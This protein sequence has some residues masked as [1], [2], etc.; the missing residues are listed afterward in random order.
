MAVPPST[1]TLQCTYPAEDG[2]PDARRPTALSGPPTVADSVRPVRRQPGDPEP[3][4][5]PAVRHDRRARDRRRLVAREEEGDARDLLGPEEPPER[6]LGGDVLPRAPAELRE[7]SEERRV[8]ASG[9]DAVGTD[10]PAAVLERHRPGQI[11]D[12]GL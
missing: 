11:D 9:T 5:E 12:R 8:D 1:R 4:G 7:E 3:G 10:V 2:D 6:V